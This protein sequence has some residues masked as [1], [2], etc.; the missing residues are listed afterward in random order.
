ME[1]HPSMG[2]VRRSL[3]DGDRMSAE[4]DVD[5]VNGYNFNDGNKSTPPTR[6]YANAGR[7]PLFDVVTGRSASTEWTPS[8]FRIDSPPAS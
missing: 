8:P 7:I 6:P 4:M 2:A 1:P 3:R 5:S